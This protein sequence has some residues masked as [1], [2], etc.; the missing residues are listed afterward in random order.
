MSVKIVT[1]AAGSSCGKADVGGQDEHV[2]TGEP[3]PFQNTAHGR[4]SGKG[5]CV[6]GEME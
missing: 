3:C 2:S 1:K 5:V 6:Q 4:C